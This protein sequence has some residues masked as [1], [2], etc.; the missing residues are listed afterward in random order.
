[1]HDDDDD[2][3][4]IDDYAHD[5]VHKHDGHDHVEPDYGDYDNMS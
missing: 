3:L 1:M 4:A 5:Y 2:E